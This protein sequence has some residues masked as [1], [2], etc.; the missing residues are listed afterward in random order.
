MVVIPTAPSTAL[1]GGAATA[2][3]AGDDDH[4]STWCFGDAVVKVAP[5]FAS[6]APYAA[7]VDSAMD[8]LDGFRKKAGFSEL[9]QAMQA[10]GPDGMHNLESLIIAPVQ[11][12]RAT[13][14]SISLSLSIY[15][16]SR[17]ATAPPCASSSHRSRPRP[18]IVPPSAQ[19][20]V[21]RYGLLMKELLK[22]TPEDHPD[23]AP[24]SRALDAVNTQAG[25]I[26]TTVGGWSNRLKLISIQ[27]ALNGRG[28]G[29]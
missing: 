10:G 28:I 3:A 13:R 26:N 20:R 23:Y 8:V 7:W 9:L 6:V 17:P 5:L 12:R 21:A 4:A 24:L 18:L 29:P 14:A 11:V 25:A 19:Q 2:P 1:E 15:I 27:D 22:Q 16:S